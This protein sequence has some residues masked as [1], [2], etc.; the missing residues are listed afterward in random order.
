MYQEVHTDNIAARAHAPEVAD[1]LQHFLLNRDG[2]GR[3]LYESFLAAVMPRF[4][5]DLLVLAPTGDGDYAFIHYGREIIRYTGASRLSERVSGMT[6]Q[7]AR[8]TI[9]C[10]DQTL[11]S[12]KP[13]YTV[14][15]SKA[16]VRVCLWERL[17]M[18]ATAAD[19]SRYVIAFSRPLQFHEEMLR[20]VLETSPSGIVALRAVRDLDGRVE[21]TVVITA[22]RRAAALARR[23]DGELLDEDARISLPFLA[24]PMVWR[25]CL[26]ALDLRRPDMIETCYSAKG[27]TAWLQIAV[28]PLGDGLV[29]TITDVTDLIVANQTLQS[30]AA[31]LALEIG[32]ERAT[33]RALSQDIEQREEREKELRRLAETDPLTA[34]LNRRSFSEKA[35]AAILDAEQSGSDISLIV[36]DLDHFKSVNDSYGHPAGDAVI[37][38]FADVLLGLVRTE[39]DLVGRFGGEEFAILL[40][41]ADLDAALR[42]A[43]RVEDALASR[44]LPVSETLALQVSASLGIA[45]RSSPET[46]AALV[47]RADRALYR[48]KN[49]GRS[50]IRISDPDVSVA[51]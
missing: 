48:A 12:G 31:T 15:R 51:A 38:A 22:N 39:R 29:L 7:V 25:R 10:C 40:P 28:A 13:T 30:R 43:L 34:L 47:E 3:V 33:R 9:A 4:G 18:P 50:C 49:E 46:L 17:L 42:I 41:G 26:Y 14:H 6:P 11:A 37:R 32:R 20:T 2:D 27:Q 16:T 36:V 8:F 1:L 24:D 21:R 23:P 5:A 45:T 35:N 19:G 44:R